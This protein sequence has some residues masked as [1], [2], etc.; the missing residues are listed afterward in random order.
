MAIRLI[1]GRSAILALSIGA[2]AALT[3][4]V[5][6]LSTP[7]VGRGAAIGGGVLAVLAVWDAVESRRAWRRSGVTL[8]RHL[9]AALAI[10]VARPIHIVVENP[11]RQSWSCTLYDR[12]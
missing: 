3:A 9:P 4:L 1:P 8:T 10:G 5:A 7:L 11:G 2:A 12:A 6:G